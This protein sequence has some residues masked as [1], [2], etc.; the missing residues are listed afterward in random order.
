MTPPPAWSP[1]G[2]PGGVEAGGGV[3]T[4]LPDI[5]TRK[6]RLSRPA[7]LARYDDALRCNRCGFCTASCPTYLATGDEGLSPRGRNQA[8]RALLEGRLAAPDDA[9]RLFSTCL[10]CGVCT[11][12]CFSQV[13]TADLMVAARGKILEHRGAPWP[14]RFILR[15]LLPR[16]R[17]FETLLKA[18]F[19]VK[20]AG[21]SRWLNRLGLLR[22]MDPRLAAAEDMAEDAP[23]SFLRGRLK[24]RPAPPE[25][26]VIQFMACGPNYVK[27]EVGEATARLLD[28]C[29]ASSRC[30]DHVCCG[31]PGLSYGDLDAARALAQKNIAALE[32]H[33]RAVIL[34]DD[35]SCAATLKDYPD[36]FRDPSLPDQ[37]AWLERAR[38]LAQRVRDLSEWLAERSPSFSSHFSPPTSHAVVTYH[39]PCKARHGQGLVDPP[40]KLLRSCSSLECRELPEADQCCGGGGTYSFM[41]PSIS[42]AVLGRKVANIQAT[43]AQV[44]LTS[45]VSCL[46]QLEFGLRKSG[47]PVKAL[48]LA[49]FLAPLKKPASSS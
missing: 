38:A 11:S 33:P 25:P 48:H 8:F 24:G 26:E 42:Q 4:T 40:R 46:L 16:P 36:L 21:V 9:E 14:L 44:V 23:L 34:V 37:A 15:A 18:A 47:S 12:V 32:A 43:G 29:G 7:D 5:Q 41:H 2:D 6:A 39:D 10:L 45:A 49:Q 19:L 28:A 27:P 17:L 1:T 30:A 3:T 13:P 35:S 31:L 22:L 20:R